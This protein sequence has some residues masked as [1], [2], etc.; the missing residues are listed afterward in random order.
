MHTIASTGDVGQFL[1]GIGTLV[2]ALAAFG[3]ALYGVLTYQGQQDDRRR[4]EEDRVRLAAEARGRWLTELLQRFSDTPTFEAVRRQ[5]Y[6][7]TD[8]ELIRALR[9]ERLLKNGEQTGVL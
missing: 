3:T 7:K 5:L 1:T 6:N 2:L 8:S 4:Q 9:R